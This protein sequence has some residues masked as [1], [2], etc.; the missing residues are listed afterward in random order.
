MDRADADKLKSLGIPPCPIVF[1]YHTTLQNNSLYNTLPIFSLH[2]A[3]L[4][5]QH[6]LSEG[7]ISAQQARNEKKAALVYSILEAAASQGK[8][9][10][11]VSKGVRSRMNIPFKFMN[12]ARDAAFLKEAEG[13]GMMQLKGHRSLGGIRVSLY[14][15]ITVEQTEK[16]AEF[17]KEYLD[18]I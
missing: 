12:E 5:F 7:G 14:N 3:D 16:F 11:L 4:V 8:V 13:R 1:D 18:K 17:L 15:A 6:L 9:Q 10:L 2:I